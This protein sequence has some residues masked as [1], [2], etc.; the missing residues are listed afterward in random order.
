LLKTEAITIIKSVAY[1]RRNYSYGVR[2]I[3][4]ERDHPKQ[5][6]LEH[7]WVVMGSLD[8]DGRRVPEGEAGQQ[9]PA[10]Q[11]LQGPK[12]HRDAADATPIQR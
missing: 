12:M 3:V 2:E 7:D 6:S 1:S 10:A 9:V 4:Q 8:G 11:P 5:V